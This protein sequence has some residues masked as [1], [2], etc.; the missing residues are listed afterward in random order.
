MNKIT[1]IFN[2][3]QRKLNVLRWHQ[4]ILLFV[5]SSLLFLLLGHCE[6]LG[7]SQTKQE[8]WSSQFKSSDWLDAWGKLERGEWGLDNLEITVEP[9]QEFEKILRVYYPAHSASP[10][11]ARKGFPLGGA[12]F[13]GTLNLPPQDALLLSYYVRFPNHFQFVKGGKL[14][15]LFGGQGNSG[16]EIPDGSDGFSTRYMWRE[17]G[18]G[19]IYAYLPTSQN[20]GTSIGR[21]R[22]RFQRN[23]WYHL[24]QKI[25]LNQPHQANGVIQVW[26]NGKEVIHQ[27]DVIFR[28]TDELKIDGILFSTFFG[29]GDSSWA[30]PEDT[31]ADFADFS[32]AVVESDD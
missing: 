24:Q 3:C 19:E 22:W 30:T 27:K 9:T 1:E 29:G 7:F 18:K 25:I 14:P 6:Q 12:Q 31:Y 32:V 21:G 5:F 16:G 10:T 15:G 8:L 4:V 13:Y 17:Q 28:T 2:H 23:Q 20:Y 26:V 11:V